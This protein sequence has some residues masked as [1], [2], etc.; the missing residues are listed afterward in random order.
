[1]KNSFRYC[2]FD[3][4]L[5]YIYFTIFRHFFSLVFPVIRRLICCL[6]RF[7]FVKLCYRIFRLKP[8]YFTNYLIFLNEPLIQ[9]R[10]T[11]FHLPSLIYIHGRFWQ[12]N[13]HTWDFF[14]NFDAMR[15]KKKKKSFSN[16]C[17][18]FLFLSNYSLKFSSSFECQVSSILK[19]IK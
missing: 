4:F 5:F 11:A 8:F 15:K 7:S 18:K 17:S 9:Y 2:L 3:L 6:W 12:N 19:L 14:F 1:M 13:A 16:C 10:K